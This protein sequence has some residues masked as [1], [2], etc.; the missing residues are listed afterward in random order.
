MMKMSTFEKLGIQ[1]SKLG[2]GCMRLPMKDG[3]IDREQALDMVEYAYQHGVNYF[4]TAWPY[5]NG[6]SEP[7][8][9]EALSRYPRDS[10][11]LATKM[12]VWLVETPEDFERIF[13]EQLQRLQTDYI[14]FYL[15]HSLNKTRFEKLVEQGLY[16]LCKKKQAEGKIR[17]IGF[18]YHDAAEHFAAL[19]DKYPWDFVQIQ[20]NYIDPH[21]LEA[22]RL[23]Q[24]LAD[25]GIPCVIMEPV[26]GGF[27]ASLP[28]DISGPF[29]ECDPARSTSSWALRWVAGHDNVKVTLSGMSNMEQ[30]KDNVATFSGDISLTDIEQKTVDRVVKRILDVHTIPCTGCEYCMP[31]P[32][33]VNIPEVFSIYNNLKL[34]RNPEMS[35]NAYFGRLKAEARADQ[36]KQCGKCMRACP[37]HIQ[38]PDMLAM[39]HAELDAACGTK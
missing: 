33:G 13:E 16:E 17:Y 14:D 5:L 18:S 10:F 29:Q 25:R 12:P 37:Q 9:G 11:Y 20:Y 23:Y 32:F 4:D 19:V 35:K 26:R 6:T 27:L 22:D 1:T 30:L 34:F 24:A 8:M 38:I 3:E 28:K 39:A 7:F 21:L 36:C 31:C 15:L 2:F